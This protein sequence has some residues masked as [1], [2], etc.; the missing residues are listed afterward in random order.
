MRSPRMLSTNQLPRTPLAPAV[1]RLTYELEGGRLTSSASCNPFFGPA[2]QL[3]LQSR[4][5]SLFAP[6]EGLIAGKSTFPDR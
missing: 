4:E 6:D 3:R 2:V 5:N 1:N